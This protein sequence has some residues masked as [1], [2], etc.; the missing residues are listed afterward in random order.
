MLTLLVLL[1]LASVVPAPEASARE[2]TQGIPPAP[3][4]LPPVSNERGQPSGAVI[5]GTV[6]SAGTGAPIPRAIVTWRC[7][8]KHLEARTAPDGRYEIATVPPGRCFGS[9]AK[10]GYATHAYGARRP[11][12]GGRPVSMEPGSRLDALDFTL[13]PAGVITGHLLDET[14]EGIPDV[15]VQA[16]RRSFLTGRL[17][18]LPV[19]SSSS[20]TDD[21][22]EFRIANL[23]PGSYYVMALA[24]RAQTLYPGTLVP[25]LATRLEARAG[26]ET[27]ADF[28]VADE[29]RVRISGMVLDSRG[30]PVRGSVTASS[31]VRFG[32]VAGGPIEPSGRFQLLVPPGEYVVTARAGTGETSESARVALGVGGADVT[33]LSVMTEP[34]VSLPGQVRRDDD[35]PLAPGVTLRPL[36]IDAREDVL[37]GGQAAPVGADGRFALRLPRGRFLLAAYGLPAG[38]AIA[39]L[40]RDGHPAPDAVLDLTAPP[41]P[42]SLELV[43]SARLTTVD[44]EVVDEN[45]ERYRE[46]TVLVFPAEAQRWP[47]FRQ[48]MRLERTD[49]EGRF[50]ARGLPPGSVERQP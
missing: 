50:S 43:V 28:R 1:A 35:N 49:Q 45:G 22:G 40:R 32:P 24:P 9:V 33:D 42:R 48:V 44:G 37:F 12:D 10:N 38:Y 27:A 26:E 8:D 21:R 5:A 19:G 46:A 30:E 29:R 4:Q 18:L 14:G 34:D 20:P 15:Q 16:L 23:A 3:R 41:D 7:G 39:Q 6:R 31:A 13:S 36:R 25:E 2:G 11:F 17:E 47:L